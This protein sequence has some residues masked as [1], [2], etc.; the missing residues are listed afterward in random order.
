MPAS[1]VACS[2]FVRSPRQL[3]EGPA[4]APCARFLT[5]GEPTEVALIDA[6]ELR[7]LERYLE[8]IA[9]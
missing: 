5:R 8:E 3:R 4:C 1:C 6:S 2:A 9:S 7:Q